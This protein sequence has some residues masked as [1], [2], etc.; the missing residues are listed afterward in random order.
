[1]LG[2]ILAHLALLLTLLLVLGYAASRWWLLRNEYL[3]TLLTLLA[4]SLLALSVRLVDTYEH[5]PGRAPQYEIAHAVETQV[6]GVVTTS[7]P[8]PTPARSN[9]RCKAEVPEFNPIQ[10]RRPV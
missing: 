2:P 9:A 5:P 3:T 4:L 8:G 6:S 7:L 1:M 10:W